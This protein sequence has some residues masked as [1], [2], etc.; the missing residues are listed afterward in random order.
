[1]SLSASISRKVISCLMS[2]V[3]LRYPAS[4]DDQ[5]GPDGELCVVGTEI[6][7]LSSDFFG[8]TFSANRNH[9]SNLIA[10]FTP[11]KTIKHFGCD[12]T[13][14][15][16]IDANVLSG[17]FERDR[18]SQA[19]DSVLGSN[20]NADLPHTNVPGHTGIV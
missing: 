18:F 2:R 19:F 9:R 4:I 8:N 7:D 1:M 3:L 16:R 17:E 10:Q 14:C 6:E 12:H 13:R 11:R 5:R 20:V 15:D